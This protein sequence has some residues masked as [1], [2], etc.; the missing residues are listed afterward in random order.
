MDEDKAR[1]ALWTSGAPVPP[2][3]VAA[4]QASAAAAPVYVSKQTGQRLVR[5]T[6]S[7]Y[8]EATRRF[9]PRTHFRPQ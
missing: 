2:A 1:Q 7:V 4:A 8:N 6:V 5:Q 3:S 9:E